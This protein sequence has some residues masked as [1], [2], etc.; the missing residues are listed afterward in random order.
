M[1]FSLLPFFFDIV[2]LWK[3]WTQKKASKINLLAFLLMIY[4]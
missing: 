1:R 3:I 2:F 4:V